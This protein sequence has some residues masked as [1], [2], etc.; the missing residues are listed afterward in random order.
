MA[1][2]NASPD[3]SPPVNAGLR[4][5]A[6]MISGWPPARSLRV[7]SQPNAANTATEAAMRANAHGGQPSVRPSTTG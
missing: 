2:K 6:G 1:V 3:T 4:N 5:R 7:S